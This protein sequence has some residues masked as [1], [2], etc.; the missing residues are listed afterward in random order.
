MSVQ[1]PREPRGLPCDQCHRR[2]VRCSG[3]TPCTPCTDVEL[4]CT[5]EIVRKKR[6]P[7]KGSG[8][9]IAKLRRGNNL[10][11]TTDPGK[12]SGDAATSSPKGGN[13]RWLTIRELA[14]YVLTDDNFSPAK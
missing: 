10:P 8:S 11:N 14:Q 13:D 3:G 1:P 6:G 7:K 5:R 4:Q 9:T 12:K 2:K